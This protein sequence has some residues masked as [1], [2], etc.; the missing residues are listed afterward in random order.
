MSRSAL[1]GRAS[2][3]LLLIAFCLATDLEIAWD[4][5]PVT[6]RAEFTFLLFGLCLAVI[7]LAHRLVGGSPVFSPRMSPGHAG[8]IGIL[9]LSLIA[10][11]C[12]FPA[13]AGIPRCWWAPHVANDLR[14]SPDACL[15]AAEP[16]V[17]SIHFGPR[18]EPWRPG[19]HN[20]LSYNYYACAAGTAECE[21]ASRWREQNAL[22]FRASFTLSASTLPGPGDLRLT[23]AGSVEVELQRT[24]GGRERVALPY[25]PTPIDR[26]VDL[27]RADLVS[28]RLIYRNY[29]CPDLVPDSPGC[30]ISP[31]T[32]TL[33]LSEAMLSVSLPRSGWRTGARWAAQLLILGLVGLIAWPVAGATWRSARALAGSIDWPASRGRASVIGLEIALLGAIGALTFHDRRSAITRLVCLAALSTLFLVLRENL[34][35]RREREAPTPDHREGTADLLCTFPILGLWIWT[36]LD[37]PLTDGFAL[38]SPGDDWLTF[39]SEGYFLAANPRWFTNPQYVFSKPL[40][41]YFRAMFYPLLGEGTTYLALLLRFVLGCTPILLVPLA[42]ST[43]RRR[44]GVLR[45]VG[46]ALF[47]YSFFWVLRSFATYLLVFPVSMSEIPA[48]LFTLVGGITLLYSIEAAGRPH[49][50]L[51]ALAALSCGL[52]LLMRPQSIAAGIPFWALAIAS[53]AGAPRRRAAIAGVASM[54]GAGLIVLVHALPSLVARREELASYLGSTTKIAATDPLPVLITTFWQRVTFEPQVGVL[55]VLGGLLGTLFVGMRARNPT[56]PIGFA[57]CYLGGL[58]LH[59][60]IKDD[61]YLP[62]HYVPVAHMAAYLSLYCGV[63]VLSDELPARVRAL[64]GR[65]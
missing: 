50:R 7:G 62:R 21:L 1:V 17:K 51:I 23:Y 42:Q 18:G 55:L 44:P 61:A 37:V 40:F 4:G 58:A 11:K 56:A 54:T 34:V 9:A 16:F 32:R 52:A 64:R 48:W 53:R 30:L 35:A 29:I 45:L 41:M 36:I 20:T 31:Q 5:L 12:F 14:L 63:R 25:A 65:D 2:W 8:A 22:P 38:Q 19:L 39:T 43:F 60:V 24:S 28:A 27:P 33:P 47:G 26:G 59:L 10:I 3:V 57:V 13:S 6:H 46:L 15:F 49:S